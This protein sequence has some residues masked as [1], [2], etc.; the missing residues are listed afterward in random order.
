MVDIDLAIL[1]QPPGA[2]AEFERNV[3]REYRFVRWP[4]Y[5]AG[6]CAVLQSFLDRP[7]VYATRWF[8]D[9]CEAQARL[10]LRHALETLG[11]GHPF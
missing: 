9:R 3:R 1:G 11:R 5:C 6:R 10:N 4:R 2:Y 7:S 8:G